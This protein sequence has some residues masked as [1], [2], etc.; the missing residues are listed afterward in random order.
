MKLN[1]EAEIRA[2]RP[3]GAKESAVTD[4]NNCSRRRRLVCGAASFTFPIID[5]CA[6]SNGA[7]S[8]AFALGL[9]EIKKIGVGETGSPYPDQTFV[10]SF[11][12]R[13][14]YTHRTC[15]FLLQQRLG[16]NTAFLHLPI[17]TENNFSGLVDIINQHALFF[18]G[19]QGEII[20]KDEIPKEMRAE[21]QDR[22]F[23]LIEHVSNVDDIL[24][25]LFLLE[26]KPTADQLRAAIR[27][28]VLGRKF[29]P[30]CLGSALK[31]KG[32]QPLLDAIIDYLPNPSEV[33]NLA[34]VEIE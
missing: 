25:D 11:A 21:S 14:T 4:V 31:N 17:G 13:I 5:N 16:L 28:A 2:R 18:D 10:F 12:S 26:K 8:L 30:V 20:R 24:G 23:E 19:P 1:G 7:F 34:N 9:R 6:S 33:E 15:D 29:I 32:V 22:L 3:C 27:R